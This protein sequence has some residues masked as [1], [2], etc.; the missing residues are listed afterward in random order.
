MQIWPSGW[1]DGVPCVIDRQAVITASFRLGSELDQSAGSCAGSVPASDPCDVLAM[2]A[3]AAHPESAGY[4]RK[5]PC[6]AIRSGRLKNAAPPVT[7]P[8]LFCSRC[9]EVIAEVKFGHSVPSCTVTEHICR[10]R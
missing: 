1:E 5:C 9:R 2:K 6:P 4:V 10:S 3:R 8:C 7:P